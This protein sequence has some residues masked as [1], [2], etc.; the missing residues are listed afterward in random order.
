[1]LSRL[2]HATGSSRKRKIWST[3][4]PY[5]LGIAS[6]AGLNIALISL[7]THRLAPSG[8]GTYSVS[9]TVIVLA[10]S[11]VGQWLQQATGR[12][13]AGSSA[14]ASAYTK[15]AVLLGAGGIML[16]LLA[17]FALIA[18]F[19]MLDSKHG[20]GL[21][22]VCLFGIAAQ[23][24]FTLVGTVLQSEQR[25]WSYSVQQACSGSL[26][27]GF[28]VL[29]CRASQQNVG[30]LLVACG[31]AQFI[32]VAFGAWQARLFDPAVLRQLGSPR[33]LLVLRKLRVYGGAMTLWFI[34]MNLAMYSDRLMVRA[35]S[36]SATAGL[37]GAASTLVVGSVSLVM[38]P[39]LAATW[40]QLMAAW[41][42]KNEHA[43]SRQL[44]DLLTYL[45]CAGVALVA[46][47]NAVAEPATRLF[48]GEKFSAASSLLALL[49][50][51]AF[52]FSLG[53]F[54]H[55]PLEFKEK[56]AT[57]CTFA[58]IVLLVNA[59]LSVILIP[60]LGG[61]GAGSAALVSG[62]L[63]CVLCAV[64]GR[65]IVKWHIRTDRLATVSVLAIAASFFARRVS[66]SW[67]FDRDLWEFMFTSASF[68]A[69]FGV[70][71]A[72]AFV[73]TSARRRLKIMG[74]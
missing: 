63:Y 15:A 61:V 3:Y 62:A 39:I 46:I 65:K 9:I 31:A 70:A 55:K 29:V 19:V 30:G 21:W 4:V 44:G 11:V 69:L 66:S 74:G 18:L 8:Y 13:L 26:K 56:K 22:L 47:V 60:R 40:P 64:Q 5:T 59:L 53:P 50:A 57:M 25:A 48:L 34:F 10:S 12:Y 41:N 67:H 32:G 1:M 42:L 14:V 54:F 52:S 73:V 28:S 58:A 38:A 16:A 45:M 49:A 43:A 6:N 33:V 2:T 7:L 37:Y 35:L 68:V 72:G 27:I 17:L 51:S 71:L 24:L 23:T 36:G 20:A